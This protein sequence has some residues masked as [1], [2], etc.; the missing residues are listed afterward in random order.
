[1]PPERQRKKMPRPPFADFSAWFAS[2][3]LSKIPKGK[4][5]AAFQRCKLGLIYESFRRNPKVLRAKWQEFARQL[6]TWN[7]AEYQQTPWLLSPWNHTAFRYW[8]KPWNKLSEK[9]QNELVQWSAAGAA[10]PADVSMRF[11]SLLPTDTSEVCRYVP[12]KTPMTLNQRNGTTVEVE[13]KLLETDTELERHGWKL[14]AIN[15]RSKDAVKR[16]CG[17]I[18]KTHATKTAGHGKV[19][20]QSWVKRLNKW[21]ECCAPSPN[22]RVTLSPKV[23]RELATAWKKSDLHPVAALLKK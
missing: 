8:S 23:L 2:N 21:S 9:Q 14:F 5:N 18:I 10:G 4:E 11:S 22:C 20:L 6:P 19:Q 7:Q 16:A 1:M 3:Y 13:R 15:C 17:W 12:P